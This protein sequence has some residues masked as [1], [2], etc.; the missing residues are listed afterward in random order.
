MFIIIYQTIIHNPIFD[1]DSN[2]SY[3]IEASILGYDGN[4]MNLKAT[5]FYRSYG[6]ST[7]FND[8]MVYLNGKFRYTIPSS[9]I[10]NAVEYYI[11]IENLNGGVIA[12]PVDNPIENPILVKQ[13]NSRLLLIIRLKIWYLI[14]KFYIQNL[15]PLLSLMSFLFLYHILRWMIL[16][17]QKQRFSLMI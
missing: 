8:K 14:M 17:F 2:K 9:F 1:L 3:N 13:K 10:Q 4:Y 11:L 5:L 15:I 16:I 7:Y 6:Q 12:F